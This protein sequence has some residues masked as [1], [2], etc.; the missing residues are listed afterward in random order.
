MRTAEEIQ[1]QYV[2]ICNNSNLIQNAINEARIEAI[3]EC[4]EIAHENA[5]VDCHVFTE[6]NIKQLLATV[7]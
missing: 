2:G 6:L 4:I 5:A 7:K 3:K 1:I